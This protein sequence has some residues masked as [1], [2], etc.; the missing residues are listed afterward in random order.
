M[1]N[2]SPRPM[3][4][5]I[6]QQPLPPIFTLPLEEQVA[7]SEDRDRSDQDELV[8]EILE[9][10]RCI[11]RRTDNREILAILDEIVWLARSI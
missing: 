5:R 6:S 8:L 3:A 9:S 2:T 10:T 4:V 1:E 11:R 7:G